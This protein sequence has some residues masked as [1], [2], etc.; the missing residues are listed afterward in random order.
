MNK[1]YLA[2]K[3]EIG[4]NTKGAEE[5]IKSSHPGEK[6]VIVN[7]KE[8][9]S[10]LNTDEGLTDWLNNPTNKELIYVM[11][12]QMSEEGGMFCIYNN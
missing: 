5:L 9:L 10:I 1:V 11:K 4:V 7:D 6:V 8:S 3:K 12:I 2:I